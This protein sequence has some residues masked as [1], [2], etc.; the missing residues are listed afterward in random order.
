VGIALS[1]L[2]GD[3]V[4]SPAGMGEAGA[5]ELLARRAKAVKKN[6]TGAILLVNRFCDAID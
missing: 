2:G 6:C 5:G 1:A 4:F 3:V